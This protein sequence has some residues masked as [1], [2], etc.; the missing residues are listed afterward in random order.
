MRYFTICS[1]H[2]RTSSNLICHVKTKVVCSDYRLKVN[3]F[4]VSC[5]RT[6]DCVNIVLRKNQK[7]FPNLNKHFK[8]KFVRNVNREGDLELLLLNCH[9]QVRSPRVQKLLTVFFENI[10]Q[11]FIQRL[12]AFSIG[13]QRHQIQT[14]FEGSKNVFT[15]QL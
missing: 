9:L 8:L 2:L 6:R 15:Q 5:R 10:N 3:D 4:P 13:K 14:E 12:P 11:E 1:S 7:L